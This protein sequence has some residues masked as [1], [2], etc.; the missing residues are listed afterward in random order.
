MVLVELGRHTNAQLRPILEQ[1]SREILEL[2]HGH[3]RGEPRPVNQLRILARV[4]Q[5]KVGIVAGVEICGK[6]QE[7]LLDSSP[8]ETKRL[9][10]V[11]DRNKRVA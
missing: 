6:I 5:E 1:R 4:H 8:L 2:C 3:S 10:L 7:I 9:Q 11:P